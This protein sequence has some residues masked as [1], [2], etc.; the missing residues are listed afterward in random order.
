MVEGSAAA[1]PST[2]ADALY[3][4]APCGLLVTTANGLILRVNRTFCV[5]VGREAG[6]LVGR[7]KLQDL[8]AVGG[9][10]FY[11]THWVPLM[12]LQGSIAEVKLEVVHTDG[13]KLPAVWNAVRRVRGETTFHEVAVIIAEDRHKYEQ[14]LLLARRQAEDLLARHQEAL[15]TLRATQ[16]ERDRMQALAEDRAQFAEQMVAIVSHDLRNPLA[17]MKMSAHI[18]GLTALTGK[19]KSALERL[20]RSNRSAVRLISDLLDFSSKRLGSG[21]QI[22]LE[23]IDLHAVVAEAVEDL[24]V[25][26]PEHILEHRRAGEGMCW[27]NSDRLAQLIGNLV[28]NAMSY[29]LAGRPIVVTSA[30]E[31]GAFSV[32]VHNQGA[33]IPEDLL[34]RLFDPMTRGSASGASAGSVGLGLFIVREIA[35]AH[36]GEIDV[37][38]SEDGGTTFKASFPRGETVSA[39]RKAIPARDSILS[40]QSRQSILDSLGISEKPEAAFDDI[41]RIAAEAC[42]VPIALIT[43]IDRDRQWFKGRVGLQM[44]EI[45]RAW[46]F[47]AHA[48]LAPS[49]VFVV[50]DAT[51]DGRFASNPFVTGEPGIRFY[52]GAPLV[53]RTGAAL[54]TVSV[55]DRE[56]R[57]LE[58]RQREVLKVLARQVVEMLEQRGSM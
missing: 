9:R 1:H 57:T 47:C 58:A 40:E 44:T 29:G 18:L 19:Q 27:G 52:A 37:T 39:A 48:I 4:D 11:Q 25:A 20:V 34:P 46:A 45:P 22:K 14:E 23:L 3:E 2:D 8:L 6:E 55:I 26:A 7:K 10:I 42:D 31:E 15:A 30:I 21:M 50:E 49:E 12:Q 17:V 35:H 32:S 53:T 33:A 36:G 51:A 28:S 16:E 56:P 13:R 41:A 54:G 24:H 5:W 43:L 38:S